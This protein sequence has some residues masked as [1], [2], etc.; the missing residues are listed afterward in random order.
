M[1]RKFYTLKPWNS[2]FIFQHFYSEYTYVF[3][4]YSDYYKHMYLY[5]K[6]S[7]SKSSTRSRI[8]TTYIASLHF[9]APNHLDV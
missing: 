5:V 9:M 2:N 1:Q 8:V 3:F 4:E 6:E 7:N